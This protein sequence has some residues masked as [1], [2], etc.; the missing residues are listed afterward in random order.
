MERFFLKLVLKNIF[1]LSLEWLSADALNRKSLR[2]FCQGKGLTL[3]SKF[4]NS[5]I[6]YINKVFPAAILFLC[7]SEY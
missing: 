4:T 3:D 6:F 1:V 2:F 5:E 7:M